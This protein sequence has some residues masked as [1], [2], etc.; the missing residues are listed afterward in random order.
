MAEVDK[1]DEQWRAELNDEEFRV[2]RE[3]GTE[4][5]WSG[6]LL[7]NKATGMYKCRG[8]GAELFPSDTKFDSG[9]GW[10]SFYKAAERSAV[11]LINDR[12][13]GMIRTEVRCATCDSHLGHLF[14]D[15]WNTPTG[16]RYCINSVCLTFEESDED[17]G[18]DSEGKAA[19][20]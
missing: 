7:N 9:S 18:H 3:N 11:T 20:E 5:A 15:G 17:S 4:P 10:P 16:N 13:F 2:L 12:S 8:C 6:E 14:D 19:G 1:T